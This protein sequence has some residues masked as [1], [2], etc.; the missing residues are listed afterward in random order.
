MHDP[1]RIISAHHPRFITPGASPPGGR[2]EVFQENLADLKS[3][4]LSHHQQLVNIY[5]K[6]N[7]SLTKCNRGNAK[8][9]SAYVQVTS[10]HTDTTQSHPIQNTYITTDSGPLC[11]VRHWFAICTISCSI[12]QLILSWNPIQPSTNSITVLYPSEFFISDR[13]SVL[14]EGCRL[15]RL[16]HRWL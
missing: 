8:I 12:T 3:E 4:H 2:T 13:S 1:R 10:S 15:R 11:Y 14:R 5:P 6:S 9:L 7:H 16:S